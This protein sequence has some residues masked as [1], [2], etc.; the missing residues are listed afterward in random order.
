FSNH[1][2]SVTI[3]EADTIMG[4]SVT[5]PGPAIVLLNDN[6]PD[7]VPV[8]SDLTVSVGTQTTFSYLGQQS[9][10]SSNGQCSVVAEGPE[11]NS[12]QPLPRTT[13]KKKKKPKMARVNPLASAAQEVEPTK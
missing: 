1:V 4:P 10:P 3:E 5:T 6:L 12:S 8:V 2:S 11:A 13:P 7:F 9:P